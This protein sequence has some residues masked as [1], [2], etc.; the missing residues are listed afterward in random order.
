M[1]WSK[2]LIPTLKEAPAEAEAI[3]HKLMLRAGLIRKL[4]SGVY[5]Y[6][7][8]G[9]KVLNKI[10]QIIREEMNRVGAQ[11]LLLPAL[12]PVKLWKES[13]RYKDIGKVMI[14]FR[15]R[16]GKE[17]ALG[18]THE[19]VITEIAKAYFKSYKQLPQVLYQ[20]QTKFRDEPRPR[21][22]VLRSC[23][24]IMKDAYS[25]DRDAEGLDVNYQKM[26]DAY[27][28]IFDRTGLDF[29]AV[30]ADS[31][32]MGGDVSHEFMMPAPGGEDTVA[33]CVACS[34]A[35]SNLTDKIKK[36]KSCPRCDAKVE[37][38]TVIEIGHIFKLGTKYSDILGAKF[39]DESGKEKSLIMGCYGIGV[40]RIIACAIEQG[41]DKHGIVWP[42]GISPY[43]AVILPLNIQD[44]K[45]KQVAFKVYEDLKKRKID[46]L[47]DD[48]NERAGI[49]L[50]D[51]DL[52]GVPCQII[53]GER[54]I[55]Q[56]RIEIKNRK[57]GGT[58]TVKISEINQ[59]LKFTV[60]VN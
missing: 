51:A 8:L 52:I 27:H 21:F 41:H 23:E 20:I 37:F 60:E 58:E 32:I 38:K 43:Q 39:L 16:R 46:V 30:E 59:F 1:L 3:S 29:L 7:P 53:I 19:E 34:W 24:F 13:G 10:E 9:L 26:Y 25:F 44:E 50:K 14:T 56:E 57:T 5:S 17:M 45:S 36:T 49:K 54:N 4:T 33:K 2:S 48:R 40:N 55:A 31:G 15:D 42:E 11:E 35:S 18:P 12:Q 6:L 28:R 47:L 22:G